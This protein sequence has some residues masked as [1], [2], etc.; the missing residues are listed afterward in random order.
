MRRFFTRSTAFAIV[1]AVAALGAGCSGGDDSKESFEDEVVAA[2]DTADSALANLRQP[3]STQDLI[4]R[5]RTGRD[6]LADASGTIAVT[7]APEDLAEERRRLAGAL[8]EM[9]QEMDAAANSIE[10]VEGSDGS[11]QSHVQTLVFDTWDRV[12]AA[13]D[14]LRDEGIDVQPLR[15]HGGAES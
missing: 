7:E 10:L 2:R 1:L 14:A 15:R 12:Q 4:L 3:D 6:E 8:S 11:E 5:L 13:L 9:S